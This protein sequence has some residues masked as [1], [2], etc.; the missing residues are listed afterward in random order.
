[1]SGKSIGKILV[2]NKSAEQG[3]Q[4]S[5]DLAKAGVPCE[6][7]CV[8]SLEDIKE[9]L[10]SGAEPDLILAWNIGAVEIAVES[11][12]DSLQ[13]LEVTKPFLVIN[14]EFSVEEQIRWMEAGAR[15]VVIGEN[16]NLLA[17]VIGRELGRT[18]QMIEPAG[19][20]QRV[21]ESAESTPETLP[22]PEKASSASSVHSAI[23]ECLKS[24]QEVRENQTLFIVE[25]MDWTELGHKYGKECEPVVHQALQAE[26]AKHLSNGAMTEVVE[27]K[28]FYH[29]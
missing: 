2:I 12:L 21:E 17:L 27:D 14:S 22:S 8:E 11:A 5:D 10:S 15:D 7:V 3:T 26:L 24:S 18:Q 25:V 9:S 16:P 20:A 4:L 6:L 23:G 19:N 28:Y 29:S 1:M 13:S